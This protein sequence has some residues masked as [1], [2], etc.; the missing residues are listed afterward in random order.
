[1]P[2]AKKLPSGSWRCQV[3]SHTEDILQPDGTIKHK[4]VYRSFTSDVPGS[5]G[6]R[7]AEQMA[8]DFA[9][10]KEDSSNVQNITVGEAM[11]R[12]ISAREKV[13]SPRTIMDYQRIRKNELTALTDLKILSI[14]QEDIQRAINLE[15]QQHS[16][17]TVRNSHGFL[18]AVLKVYRPNFALNTSLPKSVH[19]DLYVPSD[20]EIRR[21]LECAKDT[22]LE[23]PILLAA[24]GPMRRGEICALESTDI[25]GSTVH[26]TKNMVR[27]KDNEWVI[28][29]PKSYAG[30]RYIDYPDFVA[31]KWAGIVGRITPLTP[32][33]ITDRFKSLLKKSGLPHFRFH[34]LRHYSASI[35]H[36]IGIPDSYIMERGG[37]GNDGVL[38][39]VYRHA[40]SDQRKEMD[41]IANQHF[42][43]LMQH[44]I[45]HDNK[46]PT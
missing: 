28:K 36:A 16:P 37:W 30:D 46:K 35:Q 41:K 42:S 6:K 19:P 44:E 2:T 40:L 18:S 24:F 21:L 13:L 11:D 27:T 9:A 1:M 29:A 38:K 20:S 26:V 31:E 22:E 34:D 45:S 43:Q 8:A 23:L 14:T 39:S 25:T 7:L 3:Y 12:Y 32:N 4:R 10:E 5:K 33:N 15:A 17:K